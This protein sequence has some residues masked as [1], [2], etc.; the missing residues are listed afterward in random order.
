MSDA[1]LKNKALMVSLDACLDVRLGELMAVNDKLGVAVAS[2]P[3]YFTR[4]SDEFVTFDGHE[5]GKE[6][7]KYLPKDPADVL[8]FSLL[9]AI[10]PYLFQLIHELVRRNIDRPEYAQLE[11]HINTFPYKL[12]EDE[13]ETMRLV[14]SEKLK[15]SQVVKMVNY[16]P[17]TLTSGFLS[18]YLGMVLYSPLAWINAQQEELKRFKFANFM[19][20]FPKINWERKFTEEEIH[21][22]KE[23]GMNIWDLTEWAFAP[24]LKIGPTDVAV[25]S[26]Y[27]PANP[28]MTRAE[29]FGEQHSN[30]KKDDGTSSS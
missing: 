8:P 2:N 9:T 20:F 24:T 13:L 17:E 4:E 15:Y 16:P 26:A 22:M 23:H 12:R 19:L 18:T 29:L 7:K 11:V 30:E 1:I 27:I 14:F 28:R 6:Y 25:F 3:D 21:G 5:V 10:F